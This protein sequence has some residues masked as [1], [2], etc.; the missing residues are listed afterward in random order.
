MIL[1]PSWYACQ[2]FIQL[3]GIAPTS[4][5]YRGFA[6]TATANLL[7]HEFDQVTRFD[8]AFDQIFGHGSNH[9]WFVV[10]HGA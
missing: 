10:L 4:L 1:Q 6:T 9:Q 7:C 5:C 8:A 2:G 3:A